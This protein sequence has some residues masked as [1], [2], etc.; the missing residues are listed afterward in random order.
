MQLARFL[1]KVFKKGGFVLTDANSKDYII[2][3]PD[4][5]PIKLKILNK[6]LH[7]K[8][9]FHPDL[10][11]GEAY[12]NGEI[13]IE[14]GTLT[15]FLDLALMN[16]G[17][18]E[19]NFF[20]YLINRLRGSYRYLTNF[21]FIKKSKMNVSHHY[22]IKDDLY[23]LFLDPKR[24]YSCAYF[25]NENDSLETA[26]NNKIQHI[27]KK[28]NIKPDQKVLDILK[29]TDQQVICVVNKIDQLADKQKLLPFIEKLSSQYDFRAIIPISALKKNGIDDLLNSIINLLPEN[30]HLFPEDYGSNLAENSFYISEI[31]REKLTRALGDE[32][33]YELY[34]SIETNEVKG[35]VRK[36]GVKIHVAKQSQKNFDIGNSVHI[37]KKIRKA[38]RLGL[39]D[40]LGE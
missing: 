3:E 32:I 26:Q 7:Y 33:P 27:I 16:F 37:L 25:K 24:Q 19:L 5:N 22:D 4:N 11:F 17:R 34:V 36:I 21:N 8:L 15:D 2:G 35:K 9:L 40:T 39:E 23:D 1:N 18:G 28:L 14:N 10:Y 13:V 12:T 29:G 38:S 6:N 20:S 30:P 31:V